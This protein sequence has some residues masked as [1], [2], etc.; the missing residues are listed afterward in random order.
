MQ[1]RWLPKPWNVKINENYRPKVTI[2][3]P[4]YNEEKII[5]ERLINIYVQNYP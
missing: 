4:T 3:I 1:K 5:K 2:T